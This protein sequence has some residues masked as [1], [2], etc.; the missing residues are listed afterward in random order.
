MGLAFTRREFSVGAFAWL[1]CE[2]TERAAPLSG[3]LSEGFSYQFAP[4]KFSKTTTIF[5]ALPTE[6]QA[7][8]IRFG[9]LTT[10]GSSFPVSKMLACQTRASSVDHIN[11]DDNERWVPVHFPNDRSNG[12]QQRLSSDGYASPS[13]L[14][15]DFS[16]IEPAI[17][18]RSTILL[19]LT[20]AE[21]ETIW[22]LPGTAGWKNSEFSVGRDLSIGKKLGVIGPEHVSDVELL[23][24]NPIAAWQYSGGFS[25]HSILLGGDSHFSHPIGFAWRACN[26]LS[27]PDRP[28]ACWNA[29]IG[30][31]ESRV[32]LP[33][34]RRAIRDAGPSVCL[35]QGWTANDAAS[36]T[37]RY[38]SEIRAIGSDVAR[39]G[40]LPIFVT[41]FP[42]GNNT[43]Q[44]EKR[45]S[46][47]FARSRL[48]E[49]RAAGA[50]VLDA[51]PL[52][53]ESQGGVFTGDY[54]PGLTNDGIHPNN[55]AHD[56]LAQELTR[57]LRPLLHS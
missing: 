35:L 57:Q 4:E 26:S 29:A 8:R 46:W 22:G 42:R 55:A 10:P 56:I 12:S 49:Q 51:T 23:A 15:S 21:G 18:D 39:K 27:R 44:G 50:F 30:A 40:G 54:L 41:P 20:I 13:I 14:W 25:G 37:Q 28:V 11:S 1:A 43:L 24:F 48:L 16:A 33:F 53:G 19:R 6:H 5:C 7:K 31:R 36:D 34:L 32:F 52:L 9:V 47:S 38:L 2:R 45:V 3:T 17:G